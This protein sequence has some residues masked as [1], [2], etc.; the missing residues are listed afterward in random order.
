MIACPEENLQT[1]I[2][3][4]QKVT[5]NFGIEITTE[6]TETNVYFS[7]QV[8]VRYKMVV[9]KNVY[10]K[11]EFWYFGCKIYYKNEIGIQQK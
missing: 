5:E 6:K 3:I 7:G 2:F 10:N 1:G 9:D 8:P 11:K 4:L